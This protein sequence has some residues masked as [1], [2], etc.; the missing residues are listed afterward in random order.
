VSGPDSGADRRGTF[1]WEVVAG[2]M[3][4]LLLLLSFQLWRRIRSVDP[5]QRCAGAYQNV[6]TAVD[7]TLVD[8]IEV[9]WP[10]RTDRTTCGALRAAGELD[11]IPVRAPGGG[12]L[13]PPPQ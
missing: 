4:L 8:G 11:R 5:R 6:H 2:I 9:G 13:P 1:R 10:E 7:T 12:V 3:A